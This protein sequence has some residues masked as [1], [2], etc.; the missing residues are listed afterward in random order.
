MTKRFNKI[1]FEAY[2][3][4]HAWKDKEFRK[5]LLANPKAA[6]KELGYEVPSKLNITIHEEAPN[7]LTL[8]LPPS[9]ANASQLSE[10]DLRKV[11]GGTG[12]MCTGT[13]PPWAC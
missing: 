4:A 6:L 11:A 1:E 9:P 3:V 13:S 5:R 10:N 2:V 12:D 8:M 7:S